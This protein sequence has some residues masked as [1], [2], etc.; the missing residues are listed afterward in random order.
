MNEVTEQPIRGRGRPRDAAKDS[1][2]RD[3]AW[4]VLARSG[5]EGLTFEAVAEMAGCSRSTLYRRFSSKAEL[6]EAIVRETSLALEPEIGPAASPRDMLIGHSM[7]LREYMSGPRG[8]ATIRLSASI[9]ENSDL[10]EVMERQTNTDQEYY[11]SAL[12]QAKPGASE[13]RIRFATFTLIGSIIFHVAMQRSVLS[14]AQ[15]AQLVDGAL[16]ML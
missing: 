9:A 15:I 10:R 16:A 7:G 4:S 1:A 3:A 6:V 13:E 12:R 11:F 2:I 5:Y 8:L 14:E